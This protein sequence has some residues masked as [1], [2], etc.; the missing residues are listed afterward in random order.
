MPQQR[1][2]Q[3]VEA[4]AVSP[5]PMQDRLYSA[6]M[7]L[8]PLLP[9]DFEGEYRA[10][11]TGIMDALTARAAMGDEGT[12][13]ATTSTMGDDDAVAIAARIFALDAAYR[14]LR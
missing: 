6:G 10:E 13:K 14:P 5:A 4:L 7:A 2:W 9:D 12:L 3:A 8:S 1:L 11:F